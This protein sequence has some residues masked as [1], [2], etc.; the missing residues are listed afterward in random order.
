MG[1]LCDQEP[2]I[3]IPVPVVLSSQI[4][5]LLDST[6]VASCPT[7]A[8]NVITS[9]S[10]ATTDIDFWSQEMPK[11][12]ALAKSMIVDAKPA[13]AVY[14]ARYDQVSIDCGT[15]SR[16]KRS[17]EE[18][19]YL[20]KSLNWLAN[21]LGFESPTARTSASVVY[22]TATVNVVYKVKSSE[23][24]TLT[25][26]L[27]ADS[28]SSAISGVNRKKR[29]IGD[30]SD[31]NSA[32]QAFITALL[33]DVI[34]NACTTDCDALLASAVSAV[35]I[36][37]SAQTDL[38]E[39]DPCSS[40]GTDFCTNDEASNYES[41]TCTCL[42]GYSDDACATDVD[43]CSGAADTANVSTPCNS[44]GTCNDAIDSYHCT[45]G[46][47]SGGT[48]YTGTD[49]EIDWFCDSG[50]CRNGAS[51]SDGTCSCT[52]TAEF[53][54]QGTQCEA[55]NYR[56]LENIWMILANFFDLI[57]QNSRNGQ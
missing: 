33:T 29:S 51:C 45:C 37:I 44:V 10:T 9:S 8:S 48:P 53:G 13:A 27:N 6:I 32:M 42:S 39:S 15:S 12:E 38:C 47:T 43:E 3:E 23:K 18:S 11:W 25:S 20:P 49:C 4:G 22:Y 54:Y 46:L 5:S 17:A 24:D 30:T 41:R 16:K 56:K 50:L 7:G 19:S 52:V 55:I 26:V 21:I 34:Q 36:T 28:S 35:T 1:T 31:L 2:I 40:T 57:F 14:F